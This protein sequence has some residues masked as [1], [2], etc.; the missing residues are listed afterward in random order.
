VKPETA[1][2]MIT[3]HNPPGVT[4]RG[5]A[6]NVGAQAGSKGCSEKTF[7]HTGST[8]TIAWADPATQTICVVLTSLPAQAVTPHPRDL[9]GNAVAAA[10]K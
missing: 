4:P 3:N 8:G 7:G 5:L 6:L 10:M 9:A 2:L 1:R